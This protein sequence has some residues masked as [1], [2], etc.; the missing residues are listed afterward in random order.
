M[1]RPGRGNPW[2]PY[3]SR[4]LPDTGSYRVFKLIIPIITKTQR[5]VW[6]VR[7]RRIYRAV[8]LDSLVHEP[9]NV[10]A[11]ARLQADDVVDHVI[12]LQSTNLQVSFR[13]AAHLN[14]LPQAPTSF[15]QLELRVSRALGLLG[16]LL[17]GPGGMPCS[18]GWLGH[19]LAVL[20][21]RVVDKYCLTCC[22]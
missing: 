7:R 5:A 15:S 4:R 11:V 1:A 10:F 2:L 21:P 6:R 12:H 8:H 18:G 20:P 19:W 9:E 14:L 22:L 3:I 16:A 17:P 13:L